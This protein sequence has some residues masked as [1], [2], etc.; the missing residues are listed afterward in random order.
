MKPDAANTGPIACTFPYRTTNPVLYIDT[1]NQ[2]F[3]GVRFE[4]RVT[5][6]APDIAFVNCEFV[7]PPAGPGVSAPSFASLVYTTHANCRNIVF[8]HC[9]FRPLV[10]SDRWQACLYGHDW[11]IEECDLSGT[12]DALGSTGNVNAFGSYIHDLA[13]WCPDSGQ[14]DNISHNDGLQ[15]H[16]AAGHRG[17]LVDGCN[18]EAFIDPTCPDYK[19]PEYRDGKLIAGHEFYGS[20]RRADLSRSCTGILGNVTAAEMSAGAEWDV[21]IRNGW[22]NGGWNAHIQVGSRWTGTH[23]N[24]RIQG[25]QWGR[26]FW[27]GE[28]RVIHKPS[29][30]H[31]GDISGNRYEDT[32]QARN[33][34]VSAA[35]WP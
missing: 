22:G 13:Y 34:G 28:G 31:F 35:P 6:R 4:C 2:V 33:Q 32:G 9:R 1:P 5:V 7:G 8:E 10:W 25:M 29:S 24:A 20:S 18:I 19:P 23:P 27:Q 14:S 16:T 17:V 21:T 15:M 11:T 3:D 26:D 30:F 12:T